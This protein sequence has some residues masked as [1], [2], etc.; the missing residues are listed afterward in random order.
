MCVLGVSGCM[1]II[2]TAFGFRD[3]TDKLMVD[4]FSNMHKYDIQVMLKGET[5]TS[6]AERIK[7]LV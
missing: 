4:M 3:T 5:S 2:I 7:K 6:A 1:A